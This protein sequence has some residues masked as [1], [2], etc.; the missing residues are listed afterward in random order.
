[1]GAGIGTWQPDFTDYLNSFAALPIDMFDMH[2]YP[3]NTTQ[4]A[5]FLGR[6]LQIADTAHAHG[7]KVGM[8]ECWL[9]KEMNSEL[10]LSAYSAIIPSRNVY[11]FWAPLDQEFLRCMVEAG[12]WKNFEFVTPF[13]TY[14]FFSYLDYGTMQ[15]VIAGMT[16]ADAANTLQSY[17]SAA[18]PPAMAAGKI[19]STGEYYSTLIH[20]GAAS[21]DAP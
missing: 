10:G 19:T 6:I 21:G 1:V 16:P 12:Y 17:E 4:Y 8:S 14:Y 5:N 9:N 18:W 13:D 15:P 2:V 7:L 20:D 11:S 3:I